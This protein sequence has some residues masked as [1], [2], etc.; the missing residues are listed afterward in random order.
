MSGVFGCEEERRS[1]RRERREAEEKARRENA[2]AEVGSVRE[3]RG[4]RDEERGG[5]KER[6]NEESG[7]KESERGGKGREDVGEAREAGDKRTRGVGGFGRGASEVQGV[8]GA[9]PFKSAEGVWE[10][11]SFP[12]GSP[13]G[14]APRGKSG[15]LGDIRFACLEFLVANYAWW[16]FDMLWSYW[17]HVL[18]AAACGSTGTRV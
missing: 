7:G 17:V 9:Q 3:V 1:G 6:T 10:A 5:R 11:A 2:A 14:S 15:G 12:S 18:E 16:G 13:G 8:S 4:R